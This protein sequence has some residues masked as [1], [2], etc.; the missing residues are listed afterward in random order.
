R[1]VA[2][3]TGT[4]VIQAGKSAVPILREGY[5]RTPARRKKD[6]GHGPFCLQSLWLSG[7]EIAFRIH[8]PYSLAGCA[9]GSQACKKCTV[10]H[11]RARRSSAL[12]SGMAQ[13]C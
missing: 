13:I 3:V 7:S 11:L 2:S 1:P 8:W 12:S 4:A 5:N 10:L 9:I 6:K